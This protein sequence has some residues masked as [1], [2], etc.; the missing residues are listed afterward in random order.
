MV[1]RILLYEGKYSNEA[2]DASTTELAEQALVKL[3]K[4]LDEVQLGFYSDLKTMESALYMRAKSGDV[5]SVKQLL[6][7]RR[8][9]EYEWWEF[10]DLNE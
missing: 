7:I 5:R 9:Y 3:F 2:W 6:S 10:I 1:K 8:H 4:Y